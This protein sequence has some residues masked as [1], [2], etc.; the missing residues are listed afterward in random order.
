MADESKTS[1]SSPATWAVQ[2][3]TNSDSGDDP[4][5][6]PPTTTDGGYEAG[7]KDP[8]DQEHVREAKRRRICPSALDKCESI[9]IKSCCS[10]N[11]NC[12]TFS[13]DPKFSCGA[14][15]PEVTPKFGSFNLV[16]A[17]GIST[18]IQEKAAEE[19]EEE[20]EKDDEI[21]EKTNNVL[22]VLGSTDGLSAD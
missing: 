21:K 6:P 15:T 2:E 10:N 3:P 4:H 12:L 13:F 14:S 20:E 5:P 1:H 18:E 16:A 7:E 17:A 9:F 11:S 19:K 22:E 8:E